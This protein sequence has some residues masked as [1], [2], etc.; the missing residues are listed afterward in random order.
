MFLAKI[1]SA[2]V[3][4]LTATVLACA[5]LLSPGPATA[6]GQTTAEQKGPAADKVLSAAQLARSA[7]AAAAVVE[8]KGR[9]RLGSA[10]CIHPSGMFLTNAHLL[11]GEITLVL[12]PGQETERI[13]A[14]GVIRM[15]KEQDLVLLRAD[16]ARDLSALPLGSDAGLEE[17]ADVWAF[18]A[19]PAFSANAAT[20]RSLPPRDARPPRMQLN[21]ALEAGHCGGPV[22]D[23]HGKVIGV[24][25]GVQGGVSFAIPASSVT[26]FAARPE[27]QFEP[28]LLGPGDLHK[29]VR[30]EARVTPVLPSAAP[31]TVDLALKPANGKEQT[32]HMQADGDMYRVTAVPVPFLPGQLALRLGA[33]FED[34]TLDA[35]ATDRTFKAG[36]QDVK[37][38]EVRG[39]RFGEPPQ[40]L[41]H[42]SK[43]LK[44]ALTG[45]DAVPMRLG[46]EKLSVSLARAV[47]VKCWP[48]TDE[49]SCTLL[50][51]QGGK[52]VFRQTVTE[53]KPIKNPGFEAGLE[54]WTPWQH[55]A[56]SRFDFDTDLSREGWQA[57]RV[58][59]S[60][61]SDSGCSQELMLKPGCWYRFSGWVR[62]RGVEPRG[63]A[64]YGTFHIRARDNVHVIAKGV[65]HGGDT[66]WTEVPITFQAPGDG[67]ARIVVCFASFGPGTGTAWFDDL[68]LVELS[69]TTNQ[70]AAPPD[71]GRLDK[72]ISHYREALQINPKD[73]MAHCNLGAALHEQGQLD[74]AIA[75][76]RKAIRLK[77]DYP[78][79]H[80]NLGNALRDKGRL[81]E[82]IAE[83]RETLRINP[84][85][86]EAYGAL[87]QALL[88]LGRFA[89]ARDATRR[90]IALLP[91]RHALRTA[92]V[93]QLQR[94]EEALRK[95]A[96]GTKTK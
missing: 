87:G 12:N 29:P 75:E 65:N 17:L 25:V 21:A 79:A 82:A 49:V 42:D 52:E 35:T 70:A 26:A 47:E 57:L 15:D 55:G 60:A 58:T 80:Y 14:A 73:A 81:D 38:S 36:D 76:H 63:A 22:L 11:Q 43:R 92:A 20:I 66:E 94:C 41:L 89:E 10:F 69:N 34:G 62:T 27:V 68:R 39:I 91:Q 24:I 28:P 33:R 54:G 56:G 19:A 59:A 9:G 71:K 18:G 30:F 40:V 37:L 93:Q 5:V 96:R 77:P 74:E 86:A 45:L 31:L 78:E 48:A 95:E 3:L 90:C 46:G 2:T 1:T 4:T 64:A 50:V 88:A 8:V 61:P 51:K 16:G 84:T 32:Y 44:G 85:D 72:A 83:Y 67:C 6:T 53:V 7:K 23:R 13:Y